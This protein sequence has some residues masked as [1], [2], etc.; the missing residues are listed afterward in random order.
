LF[1]AAAIRM[2]AR[3]EAVKKHIEE[4]R[5]QMKSQ[6]QTGKQKQQHRA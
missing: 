2:A 4:K 3:K 1:V 5:K 6:R